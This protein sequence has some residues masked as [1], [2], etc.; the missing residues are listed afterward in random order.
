[1]SEVF[2][3]YCGLFGHRVP[4]YPQWF[5]TLALK[6]WWSEESLL[7]NTYALVPLPEILVQWVGEGP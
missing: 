1:M 6:F 2:L 3:C 5:G 4:E 7:G